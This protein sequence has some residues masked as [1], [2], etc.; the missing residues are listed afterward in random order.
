M[1]SKVIN[2]EEESNHA[3]VAPL[4]TSDIGS[5]SEDF[6]SATSGESKG[7]KVKLKRFRKTL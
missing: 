2:V 1:E 3:P 6:P 4:S 5:D 7:P